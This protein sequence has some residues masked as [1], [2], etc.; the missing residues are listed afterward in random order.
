VWLDKTQWAGWI[1]C[2]DRAAPQSYDALLSLPASVLE[3][4][5]VS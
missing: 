2:A 5:R 3:Q 4:V 1:I